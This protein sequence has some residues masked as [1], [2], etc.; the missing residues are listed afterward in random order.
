MWAFVQMCK[1]SYV[2]Y[3][4]RVNKDETSMKIEVSGSISKKSPFRMDIS[5]MDAQQ[6]P[7]ITQIITQLHN[8][9]NRLSQSMTQEK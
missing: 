6:R 1:Y 2:C 5:W 4:L 8:E 7:Q 3:W 9:H